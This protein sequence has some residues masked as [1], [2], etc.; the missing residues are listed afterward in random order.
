M[1]CRSAA[2]FTQCAVKL[3]VYGDIGG[4]CRR[5]GGARAQLF[6]HISRIEIMP[7]SHG[8]LARIT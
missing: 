3:A 7:Q 1:P 6:H 2:G 4:S 8:I 5:S